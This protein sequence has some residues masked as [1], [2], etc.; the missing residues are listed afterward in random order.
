[1][2]AQEWDWFQREELIG[3]IS[4]IRVQ[5]LQVER[6]NVQ[7]RTFTRWINLHLEKCDPPL[8]VT[9]L[10]VDIQDG[11]ILM[12]LL[13][14]LSGRNLL[15]EYKSSSHRI[16]RLNNI[17]KALKFLEDSNVKLVSIDAAEIADG[18]PSLV[19]GLIWN[20]I[21]FFQIKELTGNLSRSSPSSSLSPGSGGTDSDSSYPPTPTTERSVAV[22]VKDQR[23]AIKT[24]LSWVQRK[25]RKYGVAVQ[26]FAGSWRSGLA[27]LAVIKAIDPSLV[28]MKQALE[29]ST[30]ENLEKA[31]RIAHDSLHIPRLLE[32][33]DIMVDMPDEQSIVTYVAQFLERFPE[34]DPEDFVNP[35]KEAPIESTFVRIKESPSEQ[36]SRV[37]LLSQNGEQPYTVSHETSHPPPDKVFVCD[38]LESP[39]GFSLGSAPSHKLPDSP[40]DFMHQIIDQVFQA[41]MGN[42]ES[43]TEPTP[44]SS[45]LSTRKDGR[46]SN[47]LPVKK[48]VHFET[49]LHKDASCS[50]DPF[51][52]SEFRFEGSPKA[53]KELSKQDGHASLAEVSKEKKPEQ[54]ARLVLEAASDKAPE[55]TIVDT[56]AMSQDAQL[57]QDSSFCNGNVENPASLGEKGPSPPSPRD[58]TILANS[59]ELKV[60]LLTVEP[61]DKDDYFECIPLK[62]SKFNR[63]L[64]DFAST[65]QAFVEDPSSHKKTPG[66]EEGSENYTEKPGKRKSKSPHA[67]TESTESRLEP[68][69]LETPPKDP[70]QEDQGHTLPP[71]TAADKKP[72]VYEK[73]KRKST[74]H[75]SEEEGEAEGGLSAVGGEM[76]SNP[77]STSVSLETLRSHS[78]EGLDFKPSPPL[79]KISVIPHDLF[80]YPHYEVPLAAVLEAYAEGG[81]DLKSEDADLEHPDGSYLQDSREEEEEEDEE[82]E[83]AHSSHSSCNFSLPVDN[84]YP[85]VNDHVSH[86][87]GSSEGPT[88]ASEPGS[89]PSHEDHQPMETK[90]NG[91]VESQQSQEPPTPEL[92]T[93]PLEEK[94]TEVPTSSKKKEKRK[95]MDH[96]ESSLF[97]APGT[98]RSSD[99]LEENPCE[100]KVPSRNSHSDSSI[101]I[102]RHTNRSLELDHFS[103]V[104]LRNAAD[105]DD[106]RNRLL[107]RY[108]SQ[109]LTELILQFYGIRADMKREYKHTRLSMT[110]TNSSGEAVPLGSQS[111]PNDSLTQFVQQPDVIYFILFLWLLVY[112]LL[113]FP[114]LDV[115]RL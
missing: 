13:E 76:P 22:A 25:T 51:Y 37:L 9:D 48:S 67:E 27:F 56:D 59:V 114:Q 17:A 75:H 66:E 50:K 7:K 88:S 29:D 82:E 86:V 73:A 53:T 57:P 10:F 70:E 105:V 78:E 20:I 108:N 61:M 64:V 41:S 111:P 72:E 113:L 52:S 110:G 32:P 91:P 94:L 84:S 3:Q 54:E 85:R 81:E 87:D 36:E 95:H 89:P 112:C 23:K 80:Y 115:S 92:S 31:F 47:S 55:D 15:H 98:V 107:N 18:N 12:A 79:S 16:F 103:Y 100:H 74:R 60:P 49:D 6:E 24:L 43:T 93:K 26:D 101:Y 44:E 1:M 39:T 97:I 28:D 42:T 104:Q 99:D 45:I 96:V 63:D 62:A 38:Q 34:L 46:R 77:P 90:E 69:K 19:L 35:D 109:K 30:R 68:I 8:E 21:L 58:N 14:V 83:E 40:T 4:D 106:R 65:S 11:K 102:R 71:E 33:E 5:N 2:A